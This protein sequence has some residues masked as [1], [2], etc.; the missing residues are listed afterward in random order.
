MYSFQDI[1]EMMHPHLRDKPGYYLQIQ[2]G[3]TFEISFHVPG[4]SLENT[5]CLVNA[6]EARWVDETTFEGMAFNL[7]LV[8]EFL[9]LKT[10]TIKNGIFC[11][12]LQYTKPSRYKFEQAPGMP[13][14]QY[15]VVKNPPR[16]QQAIVGNPND[17]FVVRQA[18]PA[19][20]INS[21]R[22]G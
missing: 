22:I 9:T 1:R 6:N 16:A 20:F 13:P 11:A 4:A 8:E 7:P 21:P 2:N 12:L 15:A 18:G 17:K 19:A 14:E 5:R 3:D 10:W